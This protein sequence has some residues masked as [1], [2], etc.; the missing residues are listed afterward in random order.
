MIH[1]RRMKWVR[2]VARMGKRTAGRI[3]VEKS[4][5]KRPLGRSRRKWVDDIKSDLKEIGWGD[6]DWFDLVQDTDEWRAL[7][8][9]VKNLR[10]P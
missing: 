1:S 5:G 8:N 7:V 3:L 10:V 2:N 9:T 4:K 6:M